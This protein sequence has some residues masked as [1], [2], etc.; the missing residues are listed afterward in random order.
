MLYIVPTPIGNL[1]DITLRSIETLKSVD[2]ILCEDT[3]V[4]SKLLNHLGIKA[5]LSAF[6][7]HNEHHRLQN[8]IDA[9]KNGQN[10]ALISDAGTPGI[11]DPGFLLV[12]EARKEEIELTVLPGAT[13]LIPA[14]VASGIPCDK[15]FFEG[16]LPVKKG[17]K[18][19]LEFLLSL[20]TTLVLYESPH[21]LIKTLGHIVEY[22]GGDRQISVVREISKIHEE[23]QTDT[24]E[25]V[26]ELYKERPKVKGEIV[27]I[28]AEKAKK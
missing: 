13:A 7:A 25:N 23:V 1:G 20:N 11:S 22:F 21:K 28:I 6:H 2:Y 14:L 9:L 10:I 18:T 16:F 26:L 8:H 4:S 27:I 15:F 19:R 5:K 12:R 17:R 24:A 3:R